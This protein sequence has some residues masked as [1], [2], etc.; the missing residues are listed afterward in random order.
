MTKSKRL[1]MSEAITKKDRVA[2]A[3]VRGLSLS[4]RS[5]RYPTITEARVYS[6]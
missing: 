1:E 2:I 5:R 3:V 4:D 6:G